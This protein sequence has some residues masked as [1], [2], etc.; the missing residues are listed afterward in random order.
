VGDDLAKAARPVAHDRMRAHYA[1]LEDSIVANGRPWLI[2]EE[3]SVCDFYLGGCVR[4]SL[5]APRHATLEPESVNRRPH[6]STL[7]EALEARPSV[8]RAFE[9]EDTARSAF[10]RAPVRSQRTIKERS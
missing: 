3:L 7:L 10:F 1:M 8:I 5:I 6:L 9:A 2:G 4:W